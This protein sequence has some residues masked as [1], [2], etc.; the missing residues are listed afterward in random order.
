M[1]AIVANAGGIAAFSLVMMQRFAV[2][3]G[4]LLVVG[5]LAAPGCHAGKGLAIQPQYWTGTRCTSGCNCTRGGEN[6]YV[7]PGNPGASYQA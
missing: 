5:E 4:L 2:R 7:V 3:A 1:R 6:T